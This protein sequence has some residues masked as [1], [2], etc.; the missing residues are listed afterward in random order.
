MG[1]ECIGEEK[2]GL[3]ATGQGGVGGGNRAQNDNVKAGTKVEEKKTEKRE[4]K[5]FRKSRK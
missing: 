2:V 3:C 5:L 4:E 1:I